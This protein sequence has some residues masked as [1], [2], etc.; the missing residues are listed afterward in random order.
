MGGNRA[1]EAGEVDAGDAPPSAS[2]DA[3]GR[4]GR[5]RLPRGARPAGACLDAAKRPGVGLPP[6]TR[7]APAVASLRALQPDVRRGLRAAVRRT[8]SRPR[9]FEGMNSRAL[10]RSSV[11]RPASHPSPLG[12]PDA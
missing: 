6:R 9:A 1:A 2:A 3:G 7:A 12:A 8:S 11:W 5:V 4:G 10:A